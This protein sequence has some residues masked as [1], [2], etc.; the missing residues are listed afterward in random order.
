MGFAS[1]MA[2][3]II[4]VAASE[5]GLRVVSWAFA[6]TAFVFYGAL[7]A[8]AAHRRYVPPGVDAFAVVA[9]TAVVGSRLALAGA[10]LAAAFLLLTA[11]AIWLM[12]CVASLTNGPKL[13]GCKSRGMMIVDPGGIRVV[14]LNDNQLSATVRALP[15]GRITK[16]RPVS[17]PCVVPPALSM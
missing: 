16:V 6:G 17:A 15:S 5:L 13:K 1:V 9:A 4:S 11:V 14:L 10:H 7:V 3:G 2:T 12:I 8:L